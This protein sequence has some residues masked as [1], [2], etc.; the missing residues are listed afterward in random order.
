MIEKW[1]FIAILLFTCFI[2]HTQA[3]TIYSPYSMLGL[4]EIENND[5]GKT[6]GMSDI[7]IGIREYDYL[8]V[9]NPAGLSAL[10]SLKFIFDMS[11]SGK[12]SYFTGSGS[13]DNTLNGNLKKI[14]FGLRF[15]HWWGFSMGVK[16]FSNMGY[17][18]YSEEPIEGSTGTKAVYL[19]GN[20]GLYELYLSNGFMVSDHFSL[21]INLKYISGSLRQTEDQTDYLFENESRVF[22]FYSTFGMQYHS[23]NMT[24]GITY[25]YKQP[26]TMSNTAFIY[27]SGY[28]LLREES[29]RSSS[30]F[31]P[32]TLGVGFSYDKNKI[33]YGIDF[34][35]QKWKGT[36]SGVGSV[37]IIDS[38][39]I[40][41][42]LGFSPKGNRYYRIGSQGIRN[43]G[44][45]Q[46]GASLSQSYIQVGSSK[47]YNYSVSA[48]YSFPVQWSIMNIALEYGN[49]LSSS[50][51]Y[52]RESYFK[53]T[54][55][56]SIID[57]WFKK[58]RFD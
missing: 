19:I 57:Q 17:R 14:A 44:Q 20:G 53:L 31:I 26:I 49:T 37:S 11:V 51:S 30:Q 45:I 4:G 55:N 21:G 10:D 15:T 9:S 43:H 13:S 40:N 34:Q 50:A 48:G 33:I 7:G 56:C 42:G 52:I 47:T 28:N 12:Y 16:P 39:K 54:F 58:R 23:Q 18:I 46:A 36:E 25:G 3:Q 2:L 22:Q 29:E 6:A 27:D 35:Y 38:Y 41:A 32:E 1:P 8:N 24:I 5:H